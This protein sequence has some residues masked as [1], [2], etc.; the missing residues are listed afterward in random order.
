MVWLSGLLCLRFRCRIVGVHNFFQK[1]RVWVTGEPDS[2][3]RMESQNFGREWWKYIRDESTLNVFR[4]KTTT[5]QRTKEHQ[6]TS[7]NNINQ[8]WIQQH[9]KSRPLTE[10][11]VKATLS[12]PLSSRIILLASDHYFLTICVT[13]P[14]SLLIV[15]GIHF[16][17]LSAW[18]GRC[19]STVSIKPEK[20]GI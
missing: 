12:H 14:L 2:P 5:K 16:F 10:I 17:V 1:T 3:C 4:L 8:D 7:K 9:Q 15:P 20:L 6:A 11:M 18:W 19:N 13:T